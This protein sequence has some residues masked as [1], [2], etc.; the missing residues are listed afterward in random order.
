MRISGLD[1]NIQING[2]GTPFIWAHGLMFSIEAEDTLNWFEWNNFPRNI[3]LV[4]YDAR[5]HGKSQ[6]SYKPGDYHWKNLGK[7]MLAVADA[8]GAKQFIAGGDSMGCATA[9]CAAVQSAERMKALVHL[10]P[11]T[12]WEA[13]AAQGKLYRRFA[14]IGGL[15]GGRGLARVLRNNMERMLPAWLVQAEPEKVAGMVQGLSALKGKTLWN[16]MRGAAATN[17]PPRE[18]LEVLVDIPTI[19]LSWVGDPTHPSSTAEELHRFLPKSELFIAQGYEDA[20][21][22]PQ[23]IRDF[24]SKFA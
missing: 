23:R 20:K 6:P 22:I 12:A 7:D 10:I 2:E 24:V 3:K 17:L 4:R 5:G 16:L 13:R 19:I 8:I 1:F 21:T 15:F 18:E 14:I 9:I 11:P